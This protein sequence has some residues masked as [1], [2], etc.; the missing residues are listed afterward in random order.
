VS[1]VLVT[2]A[3]RGIGRAVLES[4]VD[5]TPVV[6]VYRSAQA[7]ADELVQRYGDR[8]TVVRAEL[9]DDA[10]VAAVVAA[11]REPLAGVVLSAGTSTHAPLVATDVLDSALRDN[12]RAPLVLL[13]SLVRADRLAE[14]SSI[15]LVG[16]NLARHGLAGAVA[17]A[18]AKAGLE[19]ATRSLAR[20]LA[21]RRIR[22]NTVAP[23]LLR[24]DMTAHRGAELDAY[25]TTVPLGRIGEAGD[26]APLVAFLLGAGAA[27]I[28]GQIIDVDGGWG[29]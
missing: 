18:A 4:I 22:V 8:V 2:G 28:T 7:A 16:S 19:G 27:Y 3:T 6:A 15:V 1:A 29:A 9:T 12:V 5:R 20:E 21:D 17:Y 10:G 11:V 13:A 23:G 24:T 14:G 25:A 26:V